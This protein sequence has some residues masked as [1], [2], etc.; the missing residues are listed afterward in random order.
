MRKCNKCNIE[1]NGNFEMC[2]L[3]NS[4]MTGKKQIMFF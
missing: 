2:P 1:F 4:S 3:S